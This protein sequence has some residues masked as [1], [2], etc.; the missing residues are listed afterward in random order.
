MLRKSAFTAGEQ[1]DVF[2]TSESHC[3]TLP[4]RLFDWRLSEDTQTFAYG[5]DEV[6]LSVWNTEL[7]FE[8]RSI[9][10]LSSSSNPIKKRKRNDGLFPGEIWRAR[11]VRAIIYPLSS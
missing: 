11:N 7:A 8:N 4:S 10:A 2:K 6:D 5:G 9:P 1:K 3:G